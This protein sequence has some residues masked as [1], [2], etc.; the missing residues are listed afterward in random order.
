MVVIFKVRLFVQQYDIS[1]NKRSQRLFD[2]S[3]L[4]GS[5]KRD[6]KIGGIIYNK[7]SKLSSFLFL[8]NNT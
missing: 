6:V 3:N 2:I 5:L 1:F 4:S 8:N 7:I